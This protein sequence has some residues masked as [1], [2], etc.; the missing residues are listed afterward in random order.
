MR[1]DG[2]LYEVVNFTQIILGVVVAASIAILVYLIMRE[3]KKG[4]RILVR[5]RH[6]RQAYQ[7]VKYAI[8]KE[9]KTDY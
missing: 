1:D 9:G 2:D 5:Q 7:A 8:Y 3:K 6:S 4:N